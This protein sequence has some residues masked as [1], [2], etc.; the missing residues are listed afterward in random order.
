MSESSSPHTPFQGVNSAPDLRDDDSDRG[1]GVYSQICVQQRLSID[2]NPTATYIA[3]GKALTWKV[4]RL[5][6][7][8]V[9]VYLVNS[10]LW[11]NSEDVSEH[12]GGSNTKL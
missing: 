3:E 10:C 6:T 9:H 7:R 1:K 11:A 4:H 8:K 5:C 12:I 2:L